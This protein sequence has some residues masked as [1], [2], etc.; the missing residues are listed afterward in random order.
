MW[1]PINLGHFISLTLH[2]QITKVVTTKHKGVN[3]HLLNSVVMA[4]GGFFKRQDLKFPRTKFWCQNKSFFPEIQRVSCVFKVYTW[5]RKVK[6]LRRQTWLPPPHMSVFMVSWAVSVNLS[7]AR[8]IR[9]KGNSNDKVSPSDGAFSRVMTD[10]GG[11]SLLS[12]VPSPVGPRLRKQ[13]E[14]PSGNMPVGSAPWFLG[15]F[16]LQG[17]ALSS[18]TRY[19]DTEGQAK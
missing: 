2:T 17:P 5:E 4:F 11:S 15:Q 16:L 12:A 14:Q 8:V 7:W 10:V 9:G 13:A 6:F 19:C 3:K 1:V 18:F